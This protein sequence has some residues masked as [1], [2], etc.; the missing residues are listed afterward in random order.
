[1]ELVTAG[2]AGT[3]DS[4]AYWTIIMVGIVDTMNI[5]R[6]KL[7]QQLQLIFQGKLLIAVPM[8]SYRLLFQNPFSLIE[9]KLF[10]WNSTSVSLP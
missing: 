3:P 9:F 8:L 10:L 1:M 5:P 2:S 7:F 6:E 4:V